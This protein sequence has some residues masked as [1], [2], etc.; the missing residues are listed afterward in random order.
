MT[1][2]RLARMLQDPNLLE[3]ITYEELKTLSLA[4]PYAYHLHQLLW[5][6]SRQI[7]HPEA[8]QN[9][10]KAAAYANDRR[11][12]HALAHAEA[13]IAPVLELRPVTEIQ[14]Q[15]ETIAAAP[16]ATPEPAVQL[17]ATPPPASEPPVE[18]PTAHPVAQVLDVEMPTEL[19]PPVPEETAITN[20]ILP[21]AND[22]SSA[23]TEAALPTPQVT[24]PERQLTTP[25]FEEW[26]FRFQLPLLTN[27]PQVRDNQALT[28]K[29]ESEPEPIEIPALGDDP[30]PPPT[31]GPKTEAQQL[32]E[33]SVTQNQGLV[34]ETL[35]RLYAA[36]G[37]KEKAIAMYERLCLANPEKSSSFAAAIEKL[38]Q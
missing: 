5:L 4:Y 31:R 17:A 11:V 1:A 28:T 32:A 20:E 33:R 36:Q 12:L 23:T 10:A 34:S 3:S 9:L 16:A 15:L 24:I 2:E 6:K 25:T 30:P 8:T 14:R 18:A 19:P 13:I 27:T 37:H 22:A 7:N 29:I 35:A 26:V 38:K 21:E